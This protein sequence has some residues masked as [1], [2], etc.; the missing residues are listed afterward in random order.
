MLGV[1][2]AAANSAIFRCETADVRWRDDGTN[3]T[4]TAG[5]LLKAGEE[6]PYDGNLNS[7]KFIR[8]SAD[9]TLDASYYRDH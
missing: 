1:S 5:Y 4:S 7:L 8:V 2:R 9:A 3:P 6:L